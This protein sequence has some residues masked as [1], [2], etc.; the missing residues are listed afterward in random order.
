MQPL[1]YQKLASDVYFQEFIKD[2]IQRMGVSSEDIDTLFSPNN[3]VENMEEFAKCFITK[4][5]D[6]NY[7]YEVYELAGDSS[8]N[9]A[10]VMYFLNQIKSAQEQY[11]KTHPNFAPGKNTIDYFNKLKA[12]YI[13]VKEL[14]DIAI[15]LGFDEFLQLGD[16][17]EIRRK[18]PD[19]DADKLVTDSFEAFIGCFEFMVDRY[20]KHLYGHYYVS[21][22]I[23]YLYTSRK[24]DYRPEALY[25]NI[26]LLKETNDI[27]RRNKNPPFQYL[28]KN[29]DGASCL[30]YSEGQLQGLNNVYRQ[31][32]FAVIKKVP[33]MFGSSKT[34]ENAMSGAALKYLKDLARNSGG[35]DPLSADASVVINETDI[36][37]APDADV[38]GITSLIESNFNNE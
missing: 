27:L 36:R 16:L 33:S 28:I 31:L 30:I 5:C 26:T 29:I 24:I 9:N 21:N 1:A 6:E 13:S 23:H 22:F 10:I 17:T 11:K 25:D 4:Y 35:R 3:E 32:T 15:R 37:I 38:F 18:N 12:L 19:F 7:N 2:L 34:V 20:L 14:N 8:I